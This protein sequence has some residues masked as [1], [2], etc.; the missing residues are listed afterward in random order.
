MFLKLFL[1]FTLIPVIEIYLLV[2][3]G[4]KVGSINAIML[5]I[6]SGIA[7]AYLARL[8]GLK[9]MI[10]IRSSLEQGI[11]PAEELIDGGIILGAGVVLLTPGFITDIVGLLLLF[12]PTRHYFKIYLRTI[13]DEK[14]KENTININKTRNPSDKG[15]TENFKN[16][17]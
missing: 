11:M 14:M 9:T 16:L 2:E 8:Q 4:A 10:K 15:E 6:L 1:A 3:I 13:V 5:V 17:S 7:G 12:P